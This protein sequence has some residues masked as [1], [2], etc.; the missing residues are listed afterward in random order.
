MNNKEELKLYVPQLEELGFYKSLLSDPKTMSYNAP[1]FPPDGC[2]DF[3]REEW[4][5]WYSQWITQ[6]PMRFYA[7]LQKVS[8]GTFIGDVNF[9]FN[10]TD[11]WWDMGILIMASE[12]GKG[13]SKQGLK[14]LLDRAF[15][16]NEVKLLHNSFGKTRYAA[17][18]LHKSLGFIED[19]K[20]DEYF[21]LFLSREE[22]LK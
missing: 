9:H 22:Y 21:H 4:E 1:W 11:D 19:E 7:Y 13:Y 6:E 5:G 16:D 20:D 15:I 3:P 18:K 2:I 14:L 8:D 12:R 17:Y 10:S